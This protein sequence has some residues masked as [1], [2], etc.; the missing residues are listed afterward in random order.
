MASQLSLPLRTWG[1]RRPGAGRKRTLPGRPRVAHRARPEHRRAHPVHVT[2]RASRRVG[3]LRRLIHAARAAIRR[4]SGDAFRIIEFSV[5]ADHVHLLVEAD[6]KRALSRGVQGL[7][8]RLAR[9]ANGCLGRRGRVWDDRWHGRALRW[10]REVRNV[11]VYILR[12]ATKHGHVP[13]DGVDRCSSAP[14]F[15]NFVRDGVGEARRPPEAGP[16]PVRAARTWLAAQGWRRL[17]PIGPVR[18]SAEGAR[19]VTVRG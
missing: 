6:D 12:N 14:W 9:A 15:E 3:S 16:S 8:I 18:S 17:G 10:P 13:S 4:A 7:S 2:L 11:L 19:P 1:G 5:Q